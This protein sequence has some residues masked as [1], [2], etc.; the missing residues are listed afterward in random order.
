MQSPADKATR[1]YNHTHYFNVKVDVH[2]TVHP[3]I[4]RH[5]IMVKVRVNVKVHLNN[6]EM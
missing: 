5:N 1:Q 6:I 2:V 3:D 4:E